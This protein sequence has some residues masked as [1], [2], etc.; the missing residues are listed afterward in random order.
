MIPFHHYSTSHSSDNLWLLDYRGIA[1][2]VTARCFTWKSA[3]LG[4][5]GGQVQIWTV[6]K[7]CYRAG[8]VDREGGA[9]NV[10]VVFRD[11]SAI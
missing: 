10:T 11:M 9:N 5:G 1:R 7:A 6:A 4:G 8:S 3:I 2:D